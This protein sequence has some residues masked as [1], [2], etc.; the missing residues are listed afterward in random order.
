MSNQS[1]LRQKWINQGVQ[2]IDAD[3]VY[4]SDDTEIG[5][6]TL[7]EPF[8]II[9]K[10]VKIANN[11]VIKGFSHLESCTIHNNVSVGPFA[12]VRGG[13]VLAENSGVGN[14]VELKNAHLGENVKSAHLTYLGDCTIGQNTNI[15]AGTIT[16]N[17]DGFNKYQTQIGK[18]CFIGSNTVFVAPIQL[19]D[20]VLTASGSV[21]T[22][23]LNTNDLA[24]S[25]AELKIIPNGTTRFRQ[26]KQK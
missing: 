17:Y 26:R 3:T 14:F 12:R 4:L 19:G 21:I 1:E 10:G 15:G 24:I 11:C 23:D 8:V 18:N 25:R 2:F 22:K 13:T 16:C 6:G 5:A 20:D 7:I 9:G